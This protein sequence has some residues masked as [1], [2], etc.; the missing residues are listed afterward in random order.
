MD[1]RRTGESDQD[2]IFAS[3]ISPLELIPDYIDEIFLVDNTCYSVKLERG[4]SEL[5]YSVQKRIVWDVIVDSIS[6]R[7]ASWP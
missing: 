1:H 3:H 2:L 4:G 6:Q 7:R 5:K